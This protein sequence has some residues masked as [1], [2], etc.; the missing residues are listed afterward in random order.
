MVASAPEMRVAAPAAHAPEASSDLLGGR[1]EQQAL[2]AA[3]SALTYGSL[4]AMAGDLAAFMG[5]M[6]LGREGRVGLFLP[7]GPEFAIGLFGA[8]QAGAAALPIDVT[9]KGEHL[10]ELIRAARVS[11]ILT[12]PGL[13]RRLTA[14]PECSQI[15]TLAWDPARGATRAQTEGPTRRSCDCGADPY[16]ARRGGWVAGGPIDPESDALLIATSGTTGAPKIVR[17]SHRAIRYSIA[18]HLESLGLKGPFTALQT[19]GVNYSYGLVASFL[20]TLWAG[21]T[22]AIPRFVDHPHVVQAIAQTGATVCLG[23]PAL[24]R[25][26]LDNSSAE[27]L[28][29]LSRIEVAGIGGDHCP[30]H[31]RLALA[32]ALPRT[33][34]YATYGLTEAGPRVTTLP[35]EMF[36]KKAD[37]VGLPLRGVELEV[38]DAGGRRCPPGETGLLFVR[39]RSLMNG[40]LAERRS[41]TRRSAPESGW[42]ATGDLATLD[43]DGYLSLRGRIDRQTKFR[44]RRFNPAVVE[45]CLDAHAGVVSAHVAVND[46]GDRLVATAH[47]RPSQGASLH[48]ELL[49]HCRRNLPNALVPEEIELVVDD[50]YYFKKRRI[51]GAPLA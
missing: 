16:Q 10:A 43:G 49:A 19:L 7:S 40:Y 42:Y 36:V 37:S 26:M 6:G 31:Q 21:G 44:G 46:A 32:S 51:Y 50:G 4:R 39:T 15:V 22:V 1:A 24:F 45:R 17:L 41:A 9:S 27:D 11:V 47:V 33:R 3:G 29:I 8:L 2:F 12:A 14:V 30:E 35:P 13:D 34:W 28:R 38:R 23:T 20:A 18:G 25:L 5:E 48:D